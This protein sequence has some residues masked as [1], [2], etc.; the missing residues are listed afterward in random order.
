MKK[1]HFYLILFGI[2]FV[3]SCSPVP[4]PIDHSFTVQKHLEAAK[5]WKILA[6]N[7]ADQISAVMHT[8]ADELKTL[9]PANKN[10]FPAGSS[11]M[12]QS[13]SGLPALYIQTN[14]ISDFGRSFR[15]YLITELSGLGYRISYFPANAL[16]VRWSVKKLRY[17]ADRKASGFPAKNTMAVAIGGG[18]FQLFNRNSY[19]F[20]GLLA[21]GAVAD[22]LGQTNGFLISEK[23]PH[24]EI[25]LTFTL[26]KGTRIFSRHSQAYYVNEKDFDH[27]S[28]I[29]D[30]AGETNPLKSVKFN[31][32]NQ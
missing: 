7:F 22:M 24:T 16:M 20:P 30:Y 12:G 27:Y 19:I 8:K 5:H 10:D 18:V 11:A 29:A 17:N 15:T 32:T 4:K 28:N 23:V 26:S 31:V 9:N 2:L 6:N 1:K 3:A 21:S 25:I 14:D 13:S